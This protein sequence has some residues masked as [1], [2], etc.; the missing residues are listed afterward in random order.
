MPV[1]RVHLNS[2]VY[3]RINGP[4]K[5]S[6]KVSTWNHMPKMTIHGVDKKSFAMLVP[7]VPPGICG[8]MHDNLKKLPL[9]MI[10]PNS[11]SQRNSLFIQHSRSAY[12]TRTRSST[13]SIKPPVRPPPQSICKVMIV[14][15]CHCKTVK[16][17]LRF[18]IRNIIAITIWN[19]KKLWWAHRPNPTRLH[20]N[21]SEHL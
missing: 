7:V 11:S 21:T 13:P 6:I 15:L 4:P 2:F 10:A 19:K 12:I 20:F 14:T 3:E 8:A 5:R 16:N 18:T 9:W 17:H 1:I